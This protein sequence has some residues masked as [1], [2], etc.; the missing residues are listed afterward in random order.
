MPSVCRPALKNDPPKTWRTLKEP[1]PPQQQLGGWEFDKQPPRELIRPDP[2]P[3]PPPEPVRR[4]CSF[5]KHCKVPDGQIDQHGRLFVNLLDDYGEVAVLGATERDASG[6]LPLK[7]IN[8]PHL[9]KALGG[10]AIAGTAVGEA[11]GGLVS[12][13]TTGV[14]GGLLIGLVTLVWS[15]RTGD[16]ALY[17]EDELRG[18]ATARTRVR[19]HVEQQP[20]GKLRGYAFNTERLGQWEQIPV[21]QF[22]PQGDRMVADVSGIGLIWTPAT[23]P[24]DKGRIPTLEQAPNTPAILVFPSVEKAGETFV[25]P[26]LPDDYRD[27]I[28]VF[29]ADSGV[30]PLYVV[31][32]VRLDPGVVTGQGE[33]VT[34]IWLEQASRE[35]G[36]P[37]PAQIADR[38][39]GKAFSSF[40]AFRA[41]FWR[42]V[43]DDAELSGQFNADNLER[44]QIGRAPLARY[45]DTRGG[46]KS[47]EL[48]H[49]ERVSDGGEIYNVDNVRVVTPHRHIKIHQEG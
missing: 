47:F 41:E 19:L 17:T 43:A 45:R 39:R 35:L 5:V 11:G 21:V 46:R 42:T 8:M 34:G 26:V 3:P 7:R 36:A 49:V 10:L 33:V 15:T 38:L 18:M 31:M 4:V 28:V 14:A 48:H 32:N 6:N 22:Q 1:A 40:D 27:A 16:S 12:G 29:P 25:N 13:I 2:P 44:M 23:D 30:P 37:I 9:P 24:N 20:N